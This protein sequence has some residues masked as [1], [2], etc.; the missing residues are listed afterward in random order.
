M[1]NVQQNTVHSWNINIHANTVPI[2]YFKLHIFPS[3]SES[4]YLSNKAISCLQ[5]I[6]LMDA[7]FFINVV[8]KAMSPQNSIAVSCLEGTAMKF[9]R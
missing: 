6:S 5:T 2:I 8:G 4:Q 1:R 7:F 3:F 9:K